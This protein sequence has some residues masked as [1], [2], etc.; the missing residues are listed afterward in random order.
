VAAGQP[1]FVTID[2]MRADCAPDDKG[3][4][5]TMAEY[6]LRVRTPLAPGVAFAYLADLTNVA[7]WDPGV[8]RAEQVVG[9]RP[10]VD[11]EFAITVKGLRRPLHYVTNEYEAPTRVVVQARR[12]WLT[13]LD[14]ITVESDGPGALVTYDARVML[15]GPLKVFDAFLTRAFRRS[16][17][18]AA[19]GLVDALDGARVGGVA[20]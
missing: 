5:P 6:V 7:R 8:T 20:V 1:G 18:R 13:A 19:S 3:Y 2:P 17:D 15:N 11:A 14:A 9:A 16:A 4:R 10:G 12:R